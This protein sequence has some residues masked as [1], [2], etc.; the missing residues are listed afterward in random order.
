MGRKNISHE[1]IKQFAWRKKGYKVWHRQ[2]E[3]T[4]VLVPL[5]FGLFEPLKIITKKG[6]LCIY[7]GL[8][9]VLLFSTTFQKKSCSAGPIIIFIVG[10]WIFKKYLFAYEKKLPILDILFSSNHNIHKSSCVLCFW[11]SDPLIERF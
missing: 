4:R 9:K 1:L 5:R 10:M 6:S 2:L 7:K 8:T 3:A 11:A